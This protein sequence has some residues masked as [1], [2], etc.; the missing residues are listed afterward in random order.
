MRLQIARLDLR[1]ERSPAHLTSS[2]AQEPRLPGAQPELLRIG[3]A[4]E[5]RV[6]A[7]AGQSVA[8]LLH[9]AVELLSA[10]GGH[11]EGIGR[12]V[13]PGQSNRRKL[14]SAVLRR[15]APT[16]AQVPPAVLE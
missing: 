9:H 2:A 4:D 5:N 7:S 11:Q 6:A 1:D 12:D 10:P 14:R 16:G 13:A 15:K 3:G 8:V